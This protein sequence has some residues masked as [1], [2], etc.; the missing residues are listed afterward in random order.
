[1][2]PQMCAIL[3]PCINGIL[4]LCIYGIYDP[5]I[6]GLLA[7][8]SPQTMHELQ[9]LFLTDAS[10]Q[11]KIPEWGKAIFSPLC[12]CMTPKV[13][14]EVSLPHIRQMCSY[15]MSSM[16]EMLWSTVANHMWSLTLERP[17]LLVSWNLGRL[18]KTES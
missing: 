18:P 1:M 15:C 3:S 4:A 9:E 2:C 16:C 17:N 10:N 12:V 6:N 8:L 11:R 13:R 7:P 5:C 14:W